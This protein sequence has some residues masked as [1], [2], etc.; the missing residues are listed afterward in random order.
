LH[1]GDVLVIRKPNNHVMMYIG[2]GKMIHATPPRVRIDSVY[3]YRE[4]VVRRFIE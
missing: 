4:V 3:K 2:D 1:F